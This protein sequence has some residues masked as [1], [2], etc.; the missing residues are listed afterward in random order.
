MFR[1][2]DVNGNGLLDF[3]EYVRIL[4]ILHVF[5]EEILKFTFECFDAD[6]SGAIDEEE[7]M[8]LAKTV[9]NTPMFPANFGKGV[10]RIRYRWRWFN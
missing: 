8:L 3:S 10:R 9:S 4:Y 5:E 1:L 6:G 7:F 2:V